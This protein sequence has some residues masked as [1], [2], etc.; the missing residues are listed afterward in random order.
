M[1]KKKRIP[2]TKPAKKPKAR[3]RTQLA[4]PGQGDPAALDRLVAYLGKLLSS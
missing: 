4:P 3:F 2:R 1:N